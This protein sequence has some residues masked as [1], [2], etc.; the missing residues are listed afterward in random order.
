[1]V[2]DFEGDVF[3]RRVDFDAFSDSEY[4]LDSND[5]GFF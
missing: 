2:N 3:G 5:F 4:F 1:M